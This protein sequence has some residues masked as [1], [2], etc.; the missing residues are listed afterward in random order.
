MPTPLNRREA[1]AGMLTSSAALLAAS[2]TTNNPLF[3]KEPPPAQ[4][5][6]RPRI[7]I[8]KET[9][10]ITEPL[11]PDG[12]PDYVA[13]LNQHC[14]RGVTSE[15]NAAVPF[16]QAMGPKEI[17][18]E[19][20]EKYFQMLGIA[21]LP[22]KGGYFRRSED[23]VNLHKPK[24]NGPVGEDDYQRNLL[25]EQM[26]EA[27]RRPWSR[28]EFPVWAEWL[29][30]NERP[31]ALLTEASK[32]PRRYDPWFYDKKEEGIDIS[33]AP[34]TQ[35]RETARAFAVRAMLQLH[36]GK[37]DEAWA[38][39]LACHRF[40]RLIGQGPTLVEFLVAITID[41][42][43]HAG[44]RALV[45]HAKLSAARIAALRQE[46]V[47]LPPMP[48]LAD[49]LDVGER[50]FNLSYTL[51]AICK[52]PA[53]RNEYLVRNETGA[54][55]DKESTTFMPILNAMGDVEID[56]D[57]VL[58]MGNSWFDRQV[59][60][61]RISSPIERR[62]ANADIDEDLR[63][64][65]ESAKNIKSLK[66]LS[67]DNLR[68]VGSEKIGQACVAVLLTPSICVNIADRAA[69]TSDLT[70]LAFAL[71]AYR[72]DHDAY[73][74]N[75]D[76]VAPKYIPSVPKDIF[77]NN[78]PLHYARRDNGFVLYSVGLNGRDDKG[79]SQYDDKNAD[80]GWDDL[81]VRVPAEKP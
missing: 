52:P 71:A 44:D 55:G 63:K 14:S 79:R 47:S 37:A 25:Y 18:S 11:R 80:K 3:A 49:V 78:S 75:L 35:S 61:L 43:A 10:Y 26:A 19:R 41:S 58:R 17:D 77:R 33:L 64:L 81:V 34:I 2:L 39:L 54:F 57:T 6:A 7:T 65:Q 67:P 68:K 16:W 56:W 69:M 29:D 40:A 50:L 27:A 62:K 51:A 8:S 1:L 21:P 48:N 59:K 9:T 60:V 23:Q 4:S 45:A 66:G 46:L 20:R 72:A 5:A 73:P 42:F 30:V 36:D 28:Q 38:D 53:E 76:D 12:L 32:R 13:A 74:D 70:Q 22:E 24:D 15:N 31:I